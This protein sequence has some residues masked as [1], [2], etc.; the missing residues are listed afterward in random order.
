MFDL[1]LENASGDQLTFGMG[2]PFTISVID[3]LNP[4]N[5]TINTSQIALMDGGKYISSKMEMRSMNIA[6]AIETEAAK[7]RIEVFNVLKSKQWIKVIYNG[8]YR[9]VYIEGYISS[10]GID[11]FAMKQMVTVGIL[12]PDPYFRE[13]QAIVDEMQLVTSGFHFPFASTAEPEL[14]LGVIDTEAGISITND[15]DVACGLIIEMNAIAPVSD[16]VIYDYGTQDSFGLDIDLLAGDLLVIDTRQGQKSVKLYRSGTV[17]NA[18]NNVVQGSTWLQLAANGS[19]YVY[20]V[21][22]GSASSLRVT[23]KHYNLY[24]GV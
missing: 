22:T 19:A 6:F 2:S 13:A 10:I 20:E 23:I 12:C 8:Q 11:Y 14:V 18:F 21:G 5:A 1:I 17:I 4:P 3:G 16:P 7:N 9:H 24:E 15:G